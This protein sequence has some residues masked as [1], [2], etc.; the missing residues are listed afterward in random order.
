MTYPI[1]PGKLAEKYLESV[2][3]NPD[4]TLDNFVTYRDPAADSFSD[5]AGAA[6]RKIVETI[7]AKY[8]P[9]IAPKSRQASEF[10]AEVAPLVHDALGNKQYCAD[11]EF[12]TWLAVV[13][14]LEISRWRYGAELKVANLGIGAPAENFIYRLWL[15]AEVVLDPDGADPYEL[16][17]RGSSI[18]FWRSHIFRPNYANSRSFARALVRFQYPEIGA[19]ARLG[20]NDIRQL[21]KRLTQIKS[22][23]LF[24]CLNDSEAFALIESEAQ[25]IGT[26]G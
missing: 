6:L 13:H 25:L 20:T 2:K 10:E 18:D 1:L 8:P 7:Q 11:P 21:A 3:E 14:F 12:W 24:A 22:N 19:P 16:A 15:R 9:Q 5:A 26:M 23:Q 4:T 17:R